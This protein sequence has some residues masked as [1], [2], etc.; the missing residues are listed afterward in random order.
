MADDTIVHIGENSPVHVAYKLFERIAYA[1]GK[2]LRRHP[3][4]GT[5]GDREWILDAHAEC[6]AVVNN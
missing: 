2:V 5:S 6:L 3:T 4:E 1:E